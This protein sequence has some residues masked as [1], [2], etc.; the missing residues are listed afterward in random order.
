[1]ENSNS[2]KAFLS[3]F[4]KE[5]AVG[6]HT[7]VPNFLIEHQAHL[8]IN[9]TQLNIL[10]ILL[11][12]WYEGKKLPYPSKARIAAMMGVT[13]NTVRVNI[14]KMEDNGFIKREPRKKS[15]LEGGGNDT[16]RYQLKGLINH[17]NAI[18]KDVAR[19]KRDS[20][21]EV[22]QGIERQKGSK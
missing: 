20:E 6:G 19:K 15:A 17:L 18:A 9:P 11:R 4:G 10:L 14:K 16:N 22:R 13:P 21:R 3:K 5:I 1:M 12:H 7:Q 8:G 2:N